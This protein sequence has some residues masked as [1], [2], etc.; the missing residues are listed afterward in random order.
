M[1]AVLTKKI[2]KYIQNL[3][4]KKFRDEEGVF[5]GEGPKLV[6]EFL[7]TKHEF[8]YLIATKE[9]LHKNASKF[10]ETIMAQIFE[11]EASRLQ[12][13]SHLKTANEVIGVF[14]KK[15]ET[16]S[17]LENSVSILLDD[18]QDPGNLGTIIRIADWFGI[19][20]I[21]CSPHSVDCY[22]SKVVQSTMGSLLRVNILY[23]DISSLMQQFPQ[24]PVYAALLDGTS[25]FEMKKISRG[26]ILIGNESKGIHPS[27]LDSNIH[28]ITIPKIGGAESLNAAVAAGIIVAQLVGR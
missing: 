3:G 20:N 28:K 26:F 14:R 8:V 1:S 22:N 6:N 12:Q 25:I 15:N 5:V 7:E 2:A 16:L 11:V 13:L 17:D 9:W 23:Q 21:I 27:L 4:D 24:M 19:K 10:P 18:I